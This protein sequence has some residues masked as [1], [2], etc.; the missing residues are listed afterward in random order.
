MPRVKTDL[1]RDRDVFATYFEE[2]GRNTKLPRETLKMIRYAFIFGTLCK[3]LEIIH[4]RTLFEEM[5]SSNES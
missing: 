5:N 2:I 3:E 1:E 4:N